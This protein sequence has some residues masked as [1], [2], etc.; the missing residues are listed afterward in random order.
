MRKHKIVLNIQDTTELDFNDRTNSQGPWSIEPRGTA[1]HVS[2][3]D[4]CRQPDLRAAG[5][6]GCVDAGQTAQ[7]CRWQAS[8]HQGTPALDEGYERMSERS[9]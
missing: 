1:R 3:S 6:D 5:R 9:W 2:A 8:Q 7:D 4:L